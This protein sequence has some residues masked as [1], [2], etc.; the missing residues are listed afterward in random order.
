MMRAVVVALAA[1]I[2]CGRVGF[3]SGSPIDASPSGL[4]VRYPMDDD[5][6]L[7]HVTSSV[8]ADD[9]S[10]TVCP[11][12]TVGH[13]GGGYAFDGTRSVLLPVA[14]SSLV[15]I[16][17]YT[18][19]IW[20]RPQPAGG[21]ML[22]KPLSA[23]DY[24]DP[25]KIFASSSTLTYE[26]VTNLDL[27]DF[28]TVP[29]VLTGAWHHVAASW[30]GTTKRLYVDGVLVGSDTTIPID[31]TYP[32][33]IGVDYDAGLPVDAYAGDLDEL[34]IYDRALA[35]AEIASLAAM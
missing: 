12:A 34:E 23:T 21:T 15:G 25:L 10:C 4:V 16:S 27:G 9:G 26:T 17:T 28:V 24:G 1:T 2:A 30:D 20:L 33:W 14:S 18:V 19:A 29:A 22:A 3:G 32:M 6:S 35:D 31:A 8:P 13:L 11:F 5:P 7:G